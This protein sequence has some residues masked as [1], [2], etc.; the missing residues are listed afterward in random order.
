MIAFERHVTQPY[1]I[2]AF[3]NDVPGNHADQFF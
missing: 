2:Y 1:L 3:L